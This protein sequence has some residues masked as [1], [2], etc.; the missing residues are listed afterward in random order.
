ME[1]SLLK[2]R[3][4]VSFEKKLVNLDLFVSL[5]LQDLMLLVR[6]LSLGLGGS[7]KNFAARLVALHCHEFTDTLLQLLGD[8]RLS[9]GGSEYYEPLT[10]SRLRKCSAAIAHLRNKNIQQWELIRNSCIAHRDNDAFEQLS[11]IETLDPDRLK[12]NGGDFCKIMAKIIEALT[13]EIRARMNKPAETFEQCSNL[14]QEITNT[15]KSIASGDPGWKDKPS[16]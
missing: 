14:F 11:I 6:P 1:E 7:E 2:E 5:C 16:A 15:L 12:E 13:A 8:H 3:E 4:F 10:R 9:K